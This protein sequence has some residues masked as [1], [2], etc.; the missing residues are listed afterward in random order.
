M[1]TKLLKIVLHQSAPFPPS[2]SSR[3]QLKLMLL[4]AHEGGYLMINGLFLVTCAVEVSGELWPF[5]THSEL[6]AGLKRA[7][8][9]SSNLL[10]HSE[11]PRSII[12]DLVTEKQFCLGWIPRG[13]EGR[14]CSQGVSP[15]PYHH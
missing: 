4:T 5:L 3:G 6:P 1:R 9:K 12:S 14:G 11:E 7:K 8:T 10:P 15:K 2:V 13:T